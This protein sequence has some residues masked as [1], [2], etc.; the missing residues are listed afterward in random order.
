[1]KTISSNSFLIIT[2]FSISFFFR[3]NSSVQRPEDSDKSIT[4]FYFLSPFAVGTINEIS[5]TILLTVPK[6]TDRSSL[7]PVITHTGKSINPN[8]L[9]AQD[10]S[11]PIT[12]TVVAANGSMQTYRVEVMLENV[13]TVP[14]DTVPVDTV[15]VDTVPVD[16]VPVDTVPVD[17]VPVDTVPVD[18]VPVDTVPVDT[19]PVDT[20]PVDTIPVDTIPVDTIPVDTIP[21]DTIPVDTIPVIN[22]EKSITEFYLSEFGI[23]GFINEEDKKIY[24]VI[25]NNSDVTSIKPIVKHTGKFIIPDST[26]VLDFTSPVT[27]TVTASDGS[28]SQYSVTIIKSDIP[29]LF[30]NT[31]Q[32][33]PIETKE[34]WIDG[35]S[36]RLIDEN[37]GV[38]SGTVSI[39]GRGN[40]T[41]GMPKKPYNIKLP[42]NEDKPFLGMPS[43]RNWVLLANYS[44]K[45]L[46][47]NDIAFKLGEVLDNLNWTP[48]SRHIVLYINQDYQGVYQLVE[49]IKIDPNRVNIAPTISPKQPDG[50]Y[51]V[52]IDVR[53]GENFNF[54]TSRGIV[55]N[56]KE[57][58]E[59]L[60]SV[61]EKIKSKIQ[62]VEDII[63]SDFFADTAIGYCKYI[64][65]KS[66]VDWYLA[67]EITKNND[68]VF[69]S[70]VY[71]YYDPTDHRFHMGPLWDYDI[72]LGN[73]DY[74][75]GANT[76][77]FY[78]M[79]APWISR[80][81]QDPAFVELVKTRWNEKRTDFYTLLLHINNQSIRLYNAQQINFI[82]WDILD[83][84]VWPNAVVTGSYEGEIKFLTSWLNSRL[85]WLDI[86]YNLLN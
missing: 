28:Q 19:I 43:H 34:V 20:I 71:M 54:S 36:Y 39:K 27:F 25:P 83:Q 62:T 85:Q 1:M 2:V 47:R 46:L 59:Q 81:F 16:T 22:S 15:P 50:G 74:N 32:Y 12:Y 26:M 38:L 48:R 31:P 76:E 13:D 10:F 24:A 3:C 55:F 41:W 14:V 11:N 68:A 30:I 56:C 72:A 70:S 37:D 80:L 7:I 4:S 79:G 78:I 49:Q 64:D 86:N 69:F 35:A 52:E 40:S 75:T 42:K 45:S 77:D 29:I 51:I 53:R 18:T 21:V 33:I 44:D 17:T 60:E 9:I 5:K 57:P 82:K 73:V 84:Y 58:D 65:V 63:H 67:N 8:S 61:F 6:G 66:F 23:K